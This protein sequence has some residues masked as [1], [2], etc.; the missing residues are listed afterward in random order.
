MQ[1]VT[2][3]PFVYVLQL[4]Q[5][6]YYIGI[7][8]NL[9]MRWAQHCDGNGA[10]FTKLYKPIKILEVFPNGSLQM[11]NEITLQ[12]MEKYGKDHVRGGSYCKC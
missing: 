11:E 5:N 8:M 9:N 10:G 7:T 6:N 1:S 12:Y 3:S 2:I 4:E